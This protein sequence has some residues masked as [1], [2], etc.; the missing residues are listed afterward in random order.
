MNN[1]IAVLLLSLRSKRSK[2][3]FGY[4]GQF[5]KAAFSLYRIH[6]VSGFSKVLLRYKIAKLSRKKR[7]PTIRIPAQKPPES[8]FA[9][10]AASPTGTTE[11]MTIFLHSYAKQLIQSQKF[12]VILLE[13]QLINKPAAVHHDTGK[14][15]VHSTPISSLPSL[16]KAPPNE[17]SQAANDTS[18]KPK[19][20]SG[21]ACWT[22]ADEMCLACPF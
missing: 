21:N 6:T 13:K 5:L 16:T 7:K 9:A 12:L 15:S 19:K 20:D 17:P 14:F 1:R 2:G 22:V 4:P 11:K 18:V 8:Q 3:L 10:F